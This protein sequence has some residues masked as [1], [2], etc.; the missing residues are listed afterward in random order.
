MLD[1]T[2]EITSV[3]YVHFMQARE[4]EPMNKVPPMCPNAVLLHQLSLLRQCKHYKS[5]IKDILNTQWQTLTKRVP[6]LI[7]DSEMSLPATE[8]LIYIESQGRSHRNT[9]NTT[10]LERP[11][12]KSV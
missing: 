6:F 12:A 4:I 11:K 8:M 9:P 5:K 2:L 1:L 7:T 10:F 3:R